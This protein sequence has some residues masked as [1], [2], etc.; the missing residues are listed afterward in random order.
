MTAEPLPPVVTTTV[1]DK[2]GLAIASL[3][4]GIVSFCGA[5]VPYVNFCLALFVVAGIIT[6]I[7]GLKSAKKG[8]AITGLVLSILAFCA[9]VAS[10]IFWTSVGAAFLQDPS[11]WQDPSQWENFLNQME[12]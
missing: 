10:I 12:Y 7:M 5:W 1:K 4:L 8:L 9:V 11:L 6:G 2:S 3:V